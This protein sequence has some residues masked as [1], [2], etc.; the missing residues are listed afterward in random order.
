MHLSLFTMFCPPIFFYPPNIFDKSTS[1]YAIISCQPLCATVDTALAELL[2]EPN[3]I[4][5]QTLLLLQAGTGASS[6][7]IFPH[8]SVNHLTLSAVKRKRVLRRRQ[9]SNFPC[10]HAYA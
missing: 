9:V 7:L 8:S 10:C 3:G 6:S 2:F 4:G 5:L 1:V